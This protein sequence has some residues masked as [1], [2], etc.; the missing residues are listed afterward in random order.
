MGGTSVCFSHLE[1]YF[2]RVHR[3]RQHIFDIAGLAQTFL[4][5]FH[6][7][8]SGTEAWILSSRRALCILNMV[9]LETD[10]SLPCLS[11]GFPFTGTTH[12][13]VLSPV[14]FLF[15]EHKITDLLRGRLSIAKE[16]VSRSPE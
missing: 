12:L 11:E 8:A 4:H 15:Y 9:R 2:A 13:F 10:T 14:W 3:Q 7:W 5:L 1:N 16:S 6:T